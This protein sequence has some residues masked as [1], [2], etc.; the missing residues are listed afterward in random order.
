MLE[1][2]SKGFKAARNYLQGQ[3]ELTETNIDEALREVRLSLLEADVEFNVVKAF[4]G[5]VKEKAL[6]RTVLVEGEDKKGK[7]LKLSPA[8]HFIGI[9]YEELEALM[10][11]VDTEIRLSQ[12]IGTIMMVGL[13]GTGKTT[14]TGKLAVHLKKLKHKPMLVAADIYRPAAVEQL[15]TLGRQIGVPVWHE[16]DTP[17][18][19]LAKKAFQ[20]AK[21]RQCNVIIFDTAGRLAIDDALMTELEEIKSVVWTSMA[22]S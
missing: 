21:E 18:P 11:P 15:K 14:T 12:P 22:S 6:G 4:L 8:E 2:V 9:C 17:P 13:Q 5:R 1:T 3:A 20:A 16:E 10:G 7:K 19:E